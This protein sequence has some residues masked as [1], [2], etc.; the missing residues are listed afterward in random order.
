[1]RSVSRALM[2]L[3]VITASQCGDVT[4]LTCAISP[5]WRVGG[6][7]KKQK[8]SLP[9]DKLLQTIIHNCLSKLCQISAA[10]KRNISSMQTKQSHFGLLSINLSRNHLSASALCIRDA[11][12]SATV[13]TA[14][15]VLQCE[16]RVCSLNKLSYLV[17]QGVSGWLLIT[18]H[19]EG[20]ENDCL[21][22]RKSVFVCECIWRKSGFPR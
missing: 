18:R 20:C 15:V 22:M 21:A 11:L 8:S 4:H 2:R 3:F 1:M 5:A 19:N 13:T 6:G 14:L 10:K 17:Q 16:L 7:Q 9:I 12:F